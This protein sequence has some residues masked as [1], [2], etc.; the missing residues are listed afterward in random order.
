VLGN[1]AAGD[2]PIDPASVVVTSPPT[3]GTIDDIDPGSGAITYTHGGLASADSFAYTVDDVLGTTSNA[4]TVT[5]QVADPVP[6]LPVLGR[7]ALVVLLAAGAG[8]AAYRGRRGAK[9]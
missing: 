8:L 9:R 5:I 3:A 7:L 4:A 1:D 2:E 6:G